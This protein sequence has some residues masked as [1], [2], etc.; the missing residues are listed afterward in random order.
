MLS[1]ASLFAGMAATA[2]APMLTFTFTKYKVPGEALLSALAGI[3]NAGVIAGTY[4]DKSQNT[5][6]FTLD[7]KTVTTIDDP[8]GTNSQCG[9]VNN[10]GAVVGTYID[11]NTGNDTGF[12][13]QNGSFTDIV[14][15]DGTNGTLP[16]A[17]NDNGDIVG[18]YT[19]ANGENH[20]FLLEKGK[21]KTFNVKLPGSLP[22]TTAATGINNSGDIILVYGKNGVGTR[23]ALYNG[24]KYTDISPPGNA[25][26]EIPFGINNEGDVSFTVIVSEIKNAEVNGSLLHAGS[27]YTFSYPTAAIT[28]AGGLNDKGMIAGAYQVKNFDSPVLGYVATYH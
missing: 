3:N 20:G 21:Y 16:A 26:E 22:G 19:D 13:Y 7:G 9:S 12:L 27:Y 14:E 10:S 15:P 25:P 5:H 17:I 1:C 23:A 11:P 28:Y 6:C 18:F 8:N 2:Q 24:K 4:I